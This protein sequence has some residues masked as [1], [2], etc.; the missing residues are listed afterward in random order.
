MDFI[1]SSAK[2][3]NNF[4]VSIFS[5]QKGAGERG[6][7]R[8][9][10][11][12]GT[13]KEEN[14]RV[15]FNKNFEIPGA[16]GSF[17]PPILP[18]E[19]EPA[20]KKSKPKAKAKPK[21]SLKKAATKVKLAKRVTRPTKKAAP[22]AKKATKSS[23]KAAKSTPKRNAASSPRKNWAKVKTEVLR[24]SPGRRSARSGIK[25]GFYNEQRLVAIMWKGE[26]SKSDPIEFRK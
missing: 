24:S 14:A 22:A 19:V 9:P 21:V 5:P 26:G 18:G 25:K 7:L 23:T 15:T 12:P 1:L 2:K 10:P 8:T 3:L 4:A 20:P 6:R 17:E 13:P 16:K 11:L